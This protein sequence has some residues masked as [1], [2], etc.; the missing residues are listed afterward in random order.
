MSG[1]RKPSEE[2]EDYW[3]QTSKKTLTNPFD[4]EDDVTDFKDDEVSGWL[5]VSRQ[6]EASE[7]SRTM[8]EQVKNMGDD[9]VDSIDVLSWDGKKTGEI[10]SA[11]F[12][13]DSTTGK[14]TSSVKIMPVSSNMSNSS[15]PTR[16]LSVG[17]SRAPPNQGSIKSGVAFSR[18]PSSIEGAVTSSAPRKKITATEFSKLES[19]VHLL[20]RSLDSAQRDR[21]TTLP[22][23]DTVKRLIRGEPCSLEMHRSLTNKLALLDAAV[24]MHDGNSIIAV[25]LFLKNTLKKPLFI[26]E[27]QAREDA[28]NHYLYYL[29][30]H[31]EFTELADVLRII[32]KVEEVSML[33]YKQ[34]LGQKQPADRLRSLQTCLRGQFKEHWGLAEPTEYVEDHCALL[35]RQIAIE[36]GDSRMEKEARMGIFK[37]YPRSTALPFLPVITTLFYCCIYHYDNPQNSIASPFSIKR[38]FKLSENQFLYTALTS[39]SK[40]QKWSDIETLL[41]G[42]GWFGKMKMKASIGFDKVV[43]ILNKMHAP[44]EVLDRYL[45]HIDDTDLR[46]SIAAKLNCHNTVIDTL[47][48]LKDRQQL[49]KYGSKL[50]FN[51]AERIRLDTI[52]RN[53]NNKWKN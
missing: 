12:R 45:Q 1:S 19:Q 25:V 6:K 4:F 23:E 17:Y 5:T 32:N 40:L 28:M 34:V 30:C 15:Y 53:T 22:P 47:L 49:M 52:L 8:R 21:W 35:E 13:P 26:K 29:K 33:K 24:A 42:K 27:L 18:E 46:L 50:H 14:Q 11:R 2:D 38:D 10:K 43:D 16:E 31:Y 36:Q 48:Q 41:T 9:D 37:Q 20:Q 39:R 7:L 3:A 51:S 44:P